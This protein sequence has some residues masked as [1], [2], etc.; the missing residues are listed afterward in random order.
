MGASDCSSSPGAATDPCKTNGCGSELSHG[1]CIGQ[2]GGLDHCSQGLVS[3][4]TPAGLP[5]RS[6]DMTSFKF[7][8]QKLYFN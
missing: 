4:L 7:Q 2:R 3:K 1:P 6:E 8:I 5:W